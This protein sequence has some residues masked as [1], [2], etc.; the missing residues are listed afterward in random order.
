MCFLNSHQ[1]FGQNTKNV[2]ASPSVNR[3]MIRYI[4]N[5]K[6]KDVVKAWRIQILSTSDRREMETT[7][8]NFRAVYP[9]MMV[10]WKHVSPNY[11]VR[12]GYFENKNKLM[13]LLLEIKKSYPS[14]TPV[15]DNVSKKSILGF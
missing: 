5:A 7:L 8:S 4:E 2:D 15:Y 10:D 9:E 12:A 3:L 6:S 13:P 1:G 11:Q 14:A